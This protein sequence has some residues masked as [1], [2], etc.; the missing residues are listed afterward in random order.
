MESRRKGCC[1]LACIQPGSEQQMGFRKQSAGVQTA[2]AGDT[3]EP[4]AKGDR[5]CWL[6][7]GIKGTVQVEPTKWRA[8]FVGKCV[9]EAS[10]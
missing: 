5:R 3:V 2:L 10:T 1:T 8:V 9:K 7:Y 6:C 4:T